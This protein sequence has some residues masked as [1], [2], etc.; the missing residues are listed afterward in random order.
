MATAETTTVDE[1]LPTTSTDNI[2]VTV[3]VRVPR[4]TDA[5]LTDEVTNRVTR[6]VDNNTV[7]A[8]THDFQPK[9]NGIYVTVTMIVAGH[10]VT[11]EDV[12][13]AVSDT[14]C[15]NVADN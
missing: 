6:A 9:S 7:I 5:S 3:T 15:I 2:T 10:N 12:V 1:S 11:K 14:P 4:G 8:E 13:D